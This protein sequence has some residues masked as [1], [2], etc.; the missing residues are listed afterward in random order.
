MDD[1]YILCCQSPPT[2]SLLNAEYPCPSPSCTLHMMVSTW[3]E[4]PLRNQ[5]YKIYLV[6][7]KNNLKKLQMSVH[8]R[9]NWDLYWISPKCF[10]EQLICFYLIDTVDHNVI[11]LHTGRWK[12]KNQMHASPQQVYKTLRYN[13]HTKLYSSIHFI[14]LLFALFFFSPS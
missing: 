6:E 11:S 3:I 7:C 9:L 5:F 10:P 4:S 13:M 8:Y 14:A 12:V 2:L 1:V